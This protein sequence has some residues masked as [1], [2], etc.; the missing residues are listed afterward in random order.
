MHTDS[1]PLP[2]VFIMAVPWDQKRV[3]CA[4]GLHKATGG[5]LIWDKHRDAVETWTRMLAAAGDSAAIFLEDDLVLC[6]DW[7]AKIAAVIAEHPDDAIQF[8]SMRKADLT[9]GARWEPGRTWLSTLCY[10]LPAGDA[11]SLLAYV[12]T[13]KAEHPE[14]GNGYDLGLGHWLRSQGRKYWLHVPS[15]VQHQEWPSELG[16]RSSK[17]LSLTFDQHFTVEEPK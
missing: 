4:V 6:P 8:F 15:L 17:R 1:P 14:E 16:P 10:Y 13:W 5:T 7:H 9:E 3:A 11:A 2:P 12:D